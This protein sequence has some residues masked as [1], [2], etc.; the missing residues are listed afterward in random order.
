MKHRVYSAAQ[1]FFRTK[2]LSKRL[3]TRLDVERF[4]QKKLTVMLRRIVQEFSFYQDYR[5]GSLS[6]LP[7]MSKEI[8]SDN[9]EQLNTPKLTAADVRGALAND[10]F[11]VDGYHIGQSTG[12]SGNR[13]YFVISDEERY[14]WLGTILAKTLPDALWR[15]HKVALALPGFTSLYE[16]ASS[17]SR[18]FLRFFDLSEG[19]SSWIEEFVAFDPDTI[20]AP[21][22]VLRYLAEQ[23][24]LQTKQVFSGAEVLDPLDRTIIE[25]ESGVK[26]REIYMATEGL[27][28]VSCSH[29][30]MHLAEDVMHF[31]WSKPDL[32]SALQSPIFTDFVRTTQVMARYQMNDLLELSSETCRC[33]SPYQTVQ[34]IEGRQDDM[35]LLPGE[36]GGLKHVTPDVL[37]NAVVDANPLITD[38]RIV[39]RGAQDI[40]ITLDESVPLDID[41]SVSVRVEQA[42][43]KLAIRDISVNLGRGISVPYDKKLRRV[44]REWQPS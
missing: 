15:R 28:G 42:L 1:A 38:F 32:A 5:G 2:W 23:G 7:L 13:G 27:L 22:K 19:V 37:R 35:F 43:R 33:G 18:I 14:R 34:R 44:R 39:Q 26:V 12:T 3:K 11:F 20:V 30:T 4:H 17:G 36:D 25:R 21:P 24:V 10:R 40:L 8:L 41:D 29:G 16:S 31:E 6:D 9:F